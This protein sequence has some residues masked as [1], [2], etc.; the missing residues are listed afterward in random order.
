[1]RTLI[2]VVIAAIA[3][4]FIY[5]EMFV[6]GGGEPSCKQVYESCSKKCRKT[7]TEATT[8]TACLTKCQGALEECK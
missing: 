6:G 7:E 8:Y 4:Y 3:G 1:M 2:V 5:Q